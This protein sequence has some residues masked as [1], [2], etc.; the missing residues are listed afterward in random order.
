LTIKNLIGKQGES[1]FTDSNKRVVVLAISEKYG[2]AL[3][4]YVGTAERKWLKARKLK[5]RR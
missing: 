1:L 2:M 5:E 4:M 3:V